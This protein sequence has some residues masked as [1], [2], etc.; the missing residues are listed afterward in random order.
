MEMIFENMKKHRKILFDKDHP[1]L[2]PLALGLAQANRRAV[3]LWALDLA[4]EAVEQL[5]AQLPHETRPAQ[6]LAQA[7]RWAAG[8]IRM[9]EAQA[10]ILDCHRAAKTLSDP[11]QAALCHAVGQACATVH[12]PG[13]A[14]GFPVYELTAI[15]L[16]AGA[17]ACREPV[18]SRCAQYQDR[19]LGWM[20]AEGQINGPWAAFLKRDCR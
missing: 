19:L 14:L 16:Q 4:Q 3:V 12:T 9:P 18:L 5:R 8:E 6:A 13:H 1:F 17:Q 15:V 10:A 7:R 20:D 11:A 2:T